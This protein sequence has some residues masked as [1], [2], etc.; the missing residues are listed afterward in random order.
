M[1]KIIT[2]IIACVTALFAFTSCDQDG[3]PSLVGSW[4][5]DYETYDGA[6]AATYNG[7]I[8]WTFTSNTITVHDRS[9]ASSGNVLD[10]YV[11]DD[12]IYVNDVRQFDIEELS[13]RSMVLEQLND[14]LGMK[15][16]LYFTKR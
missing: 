10:Y 5:L 14:M 15:H 7:E 16:E 6:V 3:T 9:G 1:K 8:Y 4:N 11:M 13:S 2:L 12:F